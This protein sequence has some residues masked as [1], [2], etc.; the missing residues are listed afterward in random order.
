MTPP[1][2]TEHAALSLDTV[3]IVLFVVCLVLVAL[4]ALRR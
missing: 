2:V 1:T 3:V 4:L